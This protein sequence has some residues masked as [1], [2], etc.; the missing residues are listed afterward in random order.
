MDRAELA[1]KLQPFIEECAKRQKPLEKA[2]LEEF[3]SGDPTS[4][5]LLV[6]SDWID[7]VSS[8]ES[9]EF[10]FDVL[11]DTTVVETREKIFTI[12]LIKPGSQF[13]HLP[14][15]AENSIIGIKQNTLTGHSKSAPKQPA[16]GEGRTPLLSDNTRGA[17]E[18]NRAELANKLQPF[19][20]ECAKRQKPLEQA[21]LEELVSGD[22]TSY[23]LQVKSDWIDK[24]ST[25]KSLEFL[26]DVLW[27]TTAVET[28]E[29][30]FTILLVKPGS[31]F[32][33]LPFMAENSIIGIEQNA[34]TRA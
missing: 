6:K 10:L 16:F 18:M 17:I 2:C 1:N 11:W 13:A 28:R 27:D 33:H 14:F 23:I 24:V 31:Q 29:K 19:I 30:I 20:E 8:S 34:L 26:F 12:L 5:F 32:A 21:C 25:S 15:M 4:Y 7:K 9:L 22:P 3:I